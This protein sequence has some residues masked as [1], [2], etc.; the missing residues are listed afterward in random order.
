[1]NG[2]TTNATNV[3]KSDPSASASQKTGVGLDSNSTGPV[4]AIPSSAVPMMAGA[5]GSGANATAAAN[6]ALNKKRKKDG[7]KPI[8][9][10]EGPTP[11]STSGARSNHG[12]LL[13]GEE[14][15]NH[16][17]L[18]VLVTPPK[19]IQPLPVRTLLSVPPTHQFIATPRTKQLLVRL[20]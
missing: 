7:L 6:A 9:T 14:K 3:P 4:P 17:Q 2:S 18:L 19:P 13:C 16:H 8:I 12:L 15:V 11:A 20:E 10:T 1:M 5:N